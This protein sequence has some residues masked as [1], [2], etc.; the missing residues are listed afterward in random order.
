MKYF[1]TSLDQ[2]G[3]YFWDVKGDHLS[4]SDISF[5]DIPFNPEDLPKYIKGEERSF[6]DMAFYFLNGFSICAI[7]GSCYDKRHGTR[8]VFWE[9]EVLTYVEMK[10]RML[11]IPVIKRIIEQMPFDVRWGC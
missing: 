3:H 7:Y 11:S 9:A 8:S 1:G 5:R 6:G 10:E 4:K 2:H